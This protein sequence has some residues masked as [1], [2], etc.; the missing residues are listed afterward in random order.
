MAKTRMQKVKGD[1]YYGKMAADYE[2]VRTKQPWWTIEQDEMKNLLAGL[3][4]DLSVVDIPFGTGRFVPYYLERG[5]DVFGLDA[6][7]DMIGSAQELLGVEFDKCTT[8]TGLSHELP[9]EDGQFDLLVSTRFL[10]DIILYRDVKKTLAEFARVT[11]KFAILQLGVKL[12]EPYVIPPDDER[13][14]S[15]MS[16]DQTRDMLS[17]YGFKEIDARKVKDVADKTSEI[18]HILCERV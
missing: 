13:M 4:R 11:R 15:R 17:E 3:P 10:R 2:A 18:R 12:T 14:G 6:S 1:R 8:T 16:V 9:Y 5:Y 7:K